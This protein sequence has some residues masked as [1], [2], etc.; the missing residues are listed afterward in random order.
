MLSANHSTVAMI[1]TMVKTESL[2][3]LFVSASK[4]D[5]DFISFEVKMVSVHVKFE[6]EQLLVHE[7]YSLVLL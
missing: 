7:V 3:S 2:G 1:L 6:V 4:L 5:P